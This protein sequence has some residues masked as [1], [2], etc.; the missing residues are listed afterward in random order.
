MS[1]ALLL[2]RQS[3]DECI[4]DIYKRQA[5]LVLEPRWVSLHPEQSNTD[6]AV[7]SKCIGPRLPER[8]SVMKV[9]GWEQV[10][11]KGSL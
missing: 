9:P 1:A 10:Q 2:L 8:V 7:L 6:A 3:Q 5:D 4:L 11:E